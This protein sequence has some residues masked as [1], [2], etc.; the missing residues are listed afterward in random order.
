MYVSFWIFPSQRCVVGGNGI[1]H[2]AAQVD[3]VGEVIE[4]REPFCLCE[5]Y[6]QNTP[7]ED[8]SGY[9]ELKQLL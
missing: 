8:G 7:M 4:R 6:D 9:P 5:P 3:E 1:V 2:C